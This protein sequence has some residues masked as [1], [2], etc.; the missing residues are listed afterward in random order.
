MKHTPGPWTVYFE[1]NVKDDHGRGIAACGGHGSN[2]NPEQAHNENVA[3]AKLIAAAPDLLEALKNLLE[4]EKLDDWEPSLIE[5]RIA[6]RAAINK[7]EG[8]I[9]K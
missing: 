8:N 3:N 9:R 5:S 6:A 2:R 4:N 1:F 7:A